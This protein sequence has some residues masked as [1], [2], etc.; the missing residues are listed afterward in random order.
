MSDLT[1]ASFG[2]FRLLMHAGLYGLRDKGVG[3]A[4]T[5]KRRVSTVALN[6]NVS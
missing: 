4:V 1:A 5:Q 2:F 3:F 6:V